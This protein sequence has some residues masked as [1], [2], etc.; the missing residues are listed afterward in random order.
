MSLDT[1]APRLIGRPTSGSDSVADASSWF[2]KTVF[3][4]LAFGCAP[5]PS[6]MPTIWYSRAGLLVSGTVSPT[7][8]SRVVSYP[9]ELPTA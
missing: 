7:D 2:M 1:W 8:R 5:S 9:L 4:P 6:G 3:V